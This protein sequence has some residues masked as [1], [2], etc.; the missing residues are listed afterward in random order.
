MFPKMGTRWLCWVNLNQSAS[1]RTEVS[2][3]EDKDGKHQLSWPWLV[4]VRLGILGSQ[5]NTLVESPLCSAYKT[6]PETKMTYSQVSAAE[7]LKG[8]SV[9][10]LTPVR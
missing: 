1:V 7:S 5:L 2:V 9:L 6:S 8:E 4:G 3:P 10:S